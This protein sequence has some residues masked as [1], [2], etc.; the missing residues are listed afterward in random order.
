M[1]L[2]R[3]DLG[4][5]KEEENGFWKDI[6]RSMWSRNSAPLTGLNVT[7][8]PRPVDKHTCVCAVISPIMHPHRGGNGFE[9]LCNQLSDFI[10]SRQAQLRGNSHTAAC[11]LTSSGGAEAN[12]GCLSV[13]C[14]RRPGASSCSG[15]LQTCSVIK[16]HLEMQDSE[17]A[18]YLPFYLTYR[19]ISATDEGDAP[20]Q[21]R[22]D[23]WTFA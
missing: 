13:T 7:H 9:P 15:V 5:L 16:L 8:R 21:N 1:H 20:T 2:V 6:L 12:S 17:T 11:I 18:R 22:S 10:T 4:G 14:E 3:N 23:R 19:D